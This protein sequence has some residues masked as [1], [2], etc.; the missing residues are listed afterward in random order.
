MCAAEA[1]RMRPGS[2]ATSGEKK[3]MAEDVKDELVAT[4]D[5]SDR[6][7]ADGSNILNYAVKL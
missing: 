2:L 1:V 6:T 7:G 3:R 4:D 5:D